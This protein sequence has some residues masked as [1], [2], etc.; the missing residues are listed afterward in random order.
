MR[1]IMA[2]I[3][4]L[5][6][7]MTLSGVR[8]ASADIREDLR[9]G[10]KYYE[11]GDWKRAAAAYDAAIRSGPSQVSA[12]AYGKRIGI[13]IILKDYKGGLDF[14]RRVAKPQHPDAPE[15][16]EQEALLLWA[17]NDKPGAIAVAEKA[18]AK[19]PSLFS[20]QQLIGEYYF[21]RDAA[22]T[23]AAYEAYLA[24]RPAERESRDVLPRIRLGFSYL[25]R[26]RKSVRGG[27]D[28]DAAADYTRA[29]KEFEVVARKHGKEQYAQ[30][31]ADIGLCAAYTGQSKFDQAIAVCER[32][33]SN[34]KNIDSNGSV[35]F[36][37]GRAYLAKKLPQRARTSANEYLRVRKNE[38]RGYILI[39]D[40]YFQEKEWAQ[41]LT[42]YLQAEKLTRGGGDA[43]LSI[44][45][46]KTY[47]RMPGSSGGGDNLRLAIEKLE[48]GFKADPTSFE[49]GIELGGAYLAAKKD[50]RALTTADRLIASKEFTNANPDH[51]AG[52]YLVSG[53]AQYN[54]GKLTVA[55]QR[56][57]AAV[58]LKPR[59]VQVRRGLVETIN[60]QAWNAMQG[61]D[62]DHAAAQALLVE[63]TAVDEKAPM[64]ALNLAVL[65]LDRGD[66]DRAKGYLARLQG[67]RAYAMVYARLSGRA[68]LCAKKPNR[69]AAAEHFAE[70]DREAEKNQANLMKAEIYTEWAPM[71]IDTKLDEA[72]EK[73]DIA[74]RFA[75][76]VPE[77]ANAAKRNLA[78]A[79]FRRGWR[80]IKAG[81]DADAVA[82]LERAT[83]E[84]GLLKGTEP[85]AFE[86]SYAL[87]LLEKGDNAE[88]GK[89]FKQLAA[90]GNQGAYLRP[91]YNTVGSQ[92][93]AAYTD[94]R[95][96]NP[97]A[98]QKAAGDFTKISGSASGA[99]AGKVRDLIASS[100]E[101]V[102]YDHWRGGRT[103]PANKALENAEKYANEDIKRRIINNRVALDLDKDKLS[104]LTSLNGSPP[105]ALV[106]LGIVY[107]QSG[108]PKDAYDAWRQAVAKG[109]QSKDLQNWIDAKKR[110]FGY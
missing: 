10:D 110:I 29:I 9:E 57:E 95:T 90:K 25:E 63:A 28:E 15:I 33:Q 93:F 97:A 38:P 104:T 102:A 42:A 5:V 44:R 107:D 69:A 76:Q 62:K 22:K 61:K 108:R 6:L 88:A 79:L 37:L 83:R 85:S 40:A 74:V 21:N 86:F 81:K 54:M 1:H 27:K 82:D 89:I 20:N 43:D 23:I 87:A 60:A 66:C 49:L 94:Y 19:K 39:G 7:L 30:P 101:Y 71:L 24:S 56:F 41:A 67:Q 50:D 65:T 72:V 3:C 26:G 52:L 73:L 48:T 75:S 12:E 36:N 109:V 96:N 98:R 55:R 51:A 84:P 16:L 53:K 11:D 103:G 58:Q 68:E 47:R 100:W 91:P 35:H 59:D 17:T 77:I 13:F 18:V 4:A 80:N 45:L 46:G 105:E 14:I 8:T 32:L 64:T 31:N 106:N 78:I 99:F 70:A 2:G 34:P 92:F